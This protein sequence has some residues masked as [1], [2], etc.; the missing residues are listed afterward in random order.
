MTTAENS[1]SVV[2]TP[3]RWWSTIKGPWV[4]APR[5]LRFILV[6]SITIGLIGAGAHIYAENSGRADPGTL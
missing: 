5:L 2:P 4:K 6:V 3:R 1:D